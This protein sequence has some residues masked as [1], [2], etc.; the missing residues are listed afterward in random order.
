[1]K[2]MLEKNK[3]IDETQ[4][5]MEHLHGVFTG[6]R[7]TL[8]TYAEMSETEVIIEKRI[9]K[10]VESAPKNSGNPEKVF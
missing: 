9:R 10:F 7:A 3:R 4:Q 2:A 8:S 5:H 6:G 1:M